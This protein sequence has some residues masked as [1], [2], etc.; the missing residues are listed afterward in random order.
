[1]IFNY[2]NI[3]KSVSNYDLVERYNLLFKY[4]NTKNIKDLLKKIDQ[5]KSDLSLE[6]KLSKI[7]KKITKKLNL[8]LGGIN[9]QRL[10]NNPVNIK[11]KDI[12]DILKK[13]I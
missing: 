5:I 2:K 9:I 3:I 10:N 4:T 8:V 6:N 13:I 1:M 12:L 11:K 7:N